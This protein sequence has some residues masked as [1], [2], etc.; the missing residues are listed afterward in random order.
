MRSSLSSVLKK[1]FESEESNP[2]LNREDCAKNICEKNW[3]TWDCDFLI[4]C[5]F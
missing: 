1:A 3:K 4:V 2:Q 5:T